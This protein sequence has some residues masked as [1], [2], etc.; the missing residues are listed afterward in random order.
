VLKHNALAADANANLLGVFD[1]LTGLSRVAV[2]VSGGSDS[3]ALLCL[4]AAWQVSLH[5][6]KDVVAVTVDHGLRNG[7]AEEAEQVHAWCR[8]LR[9]P[10][11]TLRW[12]GVKPTTGIQAKA[13]SARYDLMSD[14]CRA[15]RVPVLMT[16]HTADDQAETVLMRQARTSSDRSLAGIWP[17]NEW[18]GVKIMR[19]LLTQRR[20]DLRC[21][22]R[23]MGQGWLEDPS[24]ENDRFERVRVRKTLGGA[25]DLSVVAGDAQLRVKALDA[26]LADWLRLHCVV[27]DYAV[28]RFQRSAFEIEKPE[29]QISILSHCLRVAGDGERPERAVSEG[30][31]RWISAGQSSRRSGNGAVVS[32][33]RHVIEVMREPGRIRDRFVKVPDSGQVVFDGRFIVSAPVGS[34]VGP[35]G[36]PPALKRPKDVPGLAFSAIPMVK[37]AEGRTVCAVKSNQDGIFAMLCE[38]FSV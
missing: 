29:L 33:R 16:G 10:H 17:E 27:D 31:A 3:V 36:L 23:E 6:P 18:R 22:L 21:Y 37:L 34:M 14:W 26:A 32:A 35:M 28:L 9:I 30:M 4:A 8:T 11:E 20:E 25:A 1:G 12:M 5:G 38:R 19:P 2:A 24:N 15:N 13:R 7:S